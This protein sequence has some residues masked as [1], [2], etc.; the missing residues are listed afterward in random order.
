MVQ[1]FCFNV[2]GTHEYHAGV[3]KNVR[4]SFKGLA[5]RPVAIALDTKGPEIRTGMMTGG[6]FD[7]KTGDKIIF[8]TD[9][10]YK[11]IGSAQAIYIDYPN[12][13]KVTG[14]DKLIYIDDGNLQS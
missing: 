3:I 9:V 8:S 2:I 14:V 10:K 12:L 5:G 11:D 1:Q 7:F 13:P 6:G 4:E